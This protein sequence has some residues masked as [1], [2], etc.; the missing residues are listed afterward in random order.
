MP[1]PK[2][3]KRIH[4]LKH[5]AGVDD[6]TYRDHMESQFGVRSAK[7]LSDGQILLYCSWLEKLFDNDLTKLNPFRSLRGGDLATPKQLRML[8]RNWN[9]V[10]YA[11]SDQRLP[12]FDIFLKNRFKIKNHRELRRTDVGKVLRVLEVMK[13]QV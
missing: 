5:L 10:S 9:Q 13:K 12:A 4:T 6:D 2:L 3:I 8:M 11:P 7:E 1:H